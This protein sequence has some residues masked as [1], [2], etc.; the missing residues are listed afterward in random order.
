MFVRCKIETCP[1]DCCKL[2]ASLSLIFLSK[3]ARNTEENGQSTLQERKT[4]SRKPFGHKL[5]LVPRSLL[6]SRSSEGDTHTVVTTGCYKNT[7]GGCRVCP[8]AVN[9]CQ[10]RLKVSAPRGLNILSINCGDDLGNVKTRD[11]VS[12]TG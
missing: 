8:V 7:K 1:S 3:T 2:Q 6:T 4:V 9:N 10:I 5:L 11:T 12:L